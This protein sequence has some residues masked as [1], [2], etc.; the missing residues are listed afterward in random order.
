MK[1]MSFEIFSKN[2]KQTQKTAKLLAEEILN[3]K[4]RNNALI[5]AL[6][7]EL[8]VGKTTFIQAFA[9]G[10]GIKNKITSPTFVLMKNYKNLYHIDCYRIKNYKDILELDFEEIVSNSKNI[11]VIEWAEKIKK[12]LPKNTIWLKFKVISE[13]QR[14]IL[15]TK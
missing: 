5:L 10:L 6:Q 12:I 13:N 7:G 8:G 15:I 9:K 4:N 3:L 11:I 14:K 2:I 1:I